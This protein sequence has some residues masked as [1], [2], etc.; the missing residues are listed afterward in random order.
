M[1]SLS[2]SGWGHFVARRKVLSRGRVLIGGQG[3]CVE[4]CRQLQRER[5][6]NK[7]GEPLFKEQKRANRNVHLAVASVS[8]DIS[9]AWEIADFYWMQTTES[10]R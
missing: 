4:V 3:F 10:R 2:R 8:L 1:I 6:D 5:E 9:H 7:C